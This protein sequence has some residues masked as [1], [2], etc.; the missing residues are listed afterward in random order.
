MCKPEGRGTETSDCVEVKI[1]NFRG[2]HLD[3]LCG[4]FFENDVPHVILESNA[5]K[6]VDVHQVYVAKKTTETVEIRS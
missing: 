4:I 3:H 6:L 5:S 2:P 1:G